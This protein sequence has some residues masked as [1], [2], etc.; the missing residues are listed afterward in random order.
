MAHSFQSQP[1]YILSIVTS[2]VRVMVMIEMIIA[3]MAIIAMAMA[4]ALVIVLIAILIAITMT[5]FQQA[6][7]TCCTHPTPSSTSV[8][9]TVMTMMSTTSTGEGHQA[10]LALLLLLLSIYHFQQMTNTTPSHAMSFSLHVSNRLSKT[11]EP[12][13]TGATPTPST[14][15]SA[16][17]IARLPVSAPAPSPS[18][19]TA[20]P[21]ASPSSAPPAPST[22]TSPAPPAESV[23]VVL[24]RWRRVLRPGGVLLVSVPDLTQLA[25]MILDTKT[26]VSFKVSDSLN[27]TTAIIYA[28]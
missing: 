22:S 24:R 9:I 21:P 7:W 27:L 13:V 12:D 20:S 19:A 10:P 8:I 25:A 16:S 3:L 5:S 17:P 1:H 18:F 23:T 15:P 26:F 2:M 14:Q 28:L 6:V 11:S 4:I